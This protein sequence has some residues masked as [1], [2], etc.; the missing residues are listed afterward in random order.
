MHYYTEAYSFVALS[1]I[2]M[3]RIR[4]RL[5]RGL[6][7]SI[8]LGTPNKKDNKMSKYVIIKKYDKPF[9]L[10]SDKEQ[11]YYALYYHTRTKLLDNEPYWSMD[12]SRCKQEMY[13]VTKEQLPALLK[14]AQ[15]QTRISRKTIIKTSSDGKVFVLKLNSKK[16]AYILGR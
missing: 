13:A 5:A 7:G 1:L 15:N 9:Y 3:D 2:C 14:Q 11:S 8:P 12:T 6:R 4:V 16:L 10:G